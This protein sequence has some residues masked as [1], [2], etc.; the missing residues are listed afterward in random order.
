VLQRVAVCCSVLQCMQPVAL[1][2]SKLQLEGSTLC[3]LMNTRATMCAEL[4]AEGAAAATVF[5]SVL[6]RVAECCSVL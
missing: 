4:T 1:C 6:Q 3:V 2:C 5:E